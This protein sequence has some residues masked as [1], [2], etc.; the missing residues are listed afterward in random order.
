MILVEMTCQEASQKCSANTQEL[1]DVLEMIWKPS[2]EKEDCQPWAEFEEGEFPL[3]LLI[4]S[5][6]LQKKPCRF[7]HADPSP[8]QLLRRNEAAGHP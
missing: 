1:D 5:H 6:V 8:I 3:Q 2:C 7:G 4:L